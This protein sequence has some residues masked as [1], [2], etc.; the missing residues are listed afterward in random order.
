MKWLLLALLA[1]GANTPLLTDTTVK[2]D[3]MTVYVAYEANP[4]NTD[5]T[6]AVTALDNTPAEWASATVYHVWF[7]DATAAQF[8]DIWPN[9][10]AGH[11]RV[12]VTI[13]RLDP[14]R[15]TWTQDVIAPAVDV[16][17]N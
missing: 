13:H 10:R 1:F 8:N 2:G 14:S 12:Q 4:Y 3:K 7:I 9:M 16:E 17:V 15:P 6:V 5:V 11:F